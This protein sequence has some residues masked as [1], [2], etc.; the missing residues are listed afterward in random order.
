M[1]VGLIK[2]CDVCGESYDSGKTNHWGYCDG[3]A[4]L[5]GTEQLVKEFNEKSGDERLEILFRMILELE[6]RVADIPY[7]G[8]IN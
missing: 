5:R 1:A 2:H 3:G 4:K 8:P 6:N 7:Y